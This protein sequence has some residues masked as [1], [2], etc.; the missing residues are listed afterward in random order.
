MP[1]TVDKVAPLLSSHADA[2]RAKPPEWWIERFIKGLGRVP[3]A[4]GRWLDALAKKRVVGPVIRL[5]SS[6]VFGIVILAC[7]GLYIA[8]GSGF[9]SLRASLEMTDLQFFDA[10]PMRILLTLLVLDLTIVTLRRIPLTLFKLGPWIVHIGILTLIG[11]CVWY[12]SCKEEGSVRIYL[13]KSVNVSYDVTERALYAFGVDAGVGGEK[14]D[15]EHAAI[16]SLP[17]LPIY[18]EHLK[19]MGTPMDR[20]VPEALGGLGA[21]YKD[22]KVRITGYY[23]SATMQPVGWRA[24]VA[25]ETGNGPG[26]AVQLSDDTRTAPEDWL[27]GST[28]AGRLISGKE[29]PLEMEYLY[30][31]TAERVRE[32]QASFE[33]Q[34]G[35]VVRIPALKIERTYSSV[36]P[37]ETVVVE[38]SPYT[39]TV[40]DVGGMPMAS[41]G[42]ENAFSTALTVDVARKEGDGTTFNFQRM[43]LSRYPE[44]SPDFVMVDGK[45]VRKQEGVD[46]NIQI[47][48]E[49]A[50]Q[51]EAWIVEDEGGKL[52]VI[53]RDANGKSTTTELDAPGATSR[54]VAVPVADFPKLKLR[55]TERAADSVPEF[56]PVIV[57]KEERPRGQNAME[58]MQFSMVELEVSGGSGSSAWKQKHVIVPFSPYAEIGEPPAGEKPAVVEIPGVGKIGFLLATTQRPLPS[59][60]TLA[61]FEPVHYPGAQHAYADYISTLSVKDKA[62]AQSGVERKLVAQ[63]NAPASDHGLYYFQSAWDGDDNAPVEK[64]FTVLGVANRPGIHVMEAGAILMIVG[65]G[66][67]FYVKPILLKKKKESLAA[68]NARRLAGGA[69]LSG[70]LN[71]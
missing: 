8:L 47:G 3:G 46:A 56:E 69:G 57:P 62:G 64:R 27:V 52:A 12:F 42:Y 4:A 63:L 28:P 9:A 41:K 10:W 40:K 11:G 22:V 26:I 18:Y 68:W 31:P 30:H 44:R 36:K 51:P 37:G 45:N 15:T 6:V 50:S 14:F 67:A 70:G 19:Q 49:D 48:F 33:G 20:A 38:G 21:A 7:L 58:A 54:T 13:G 61:N 39:L 24:A 34:M 60:I 35:L 53:Y 65:I 5:F 29:T 32:L 66:Y 43:A 55:V 71:Q 2:A 1:S 16:S 17:G 25:G 23:P 59:T